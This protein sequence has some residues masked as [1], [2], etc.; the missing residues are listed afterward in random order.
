MHTN[1]TLPSPLPGPG[2]IAPWKSAASALGFGLQKPVQFLPS[3]G[4]NHNMITHICDRCGRPIE[5]GQ[6]R[7]T[8]RI[9]VFAA[10]DPMEITL[11]DL[12][13]DTR[14]E[15]DEIIGQCEP[16]SEREL[17][18]DVYVEFQFDLCRACQRIYLNDPL[19]VSGGN[20]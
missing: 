19:S 6:I 2:R 16:L 14:Q 9:Q 10:A 11:D 15:M 5:R 8:A 12:L 18:R 3:A 7:Y 17:M 20:Q 4:Y 13:R 1:F